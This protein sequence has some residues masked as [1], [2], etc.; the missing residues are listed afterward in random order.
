[1]KKRIPIGYEDFKEIIEKNLYFVDKSMLI[2][3]LADV[4][5][6]TLFTRPRRF[7]KTLN[8]SMIRRY[9]EDERTPAGEKIDNSCLFD[10]LAIMDAGEEYCSMQQQY[11]VIKLSLKSAKQPDFEMA[12]SSMIDDI[13]LEFDRHR[14]ILGTGVLSDAEEKRYRRI[15]DR[16]AE[17]AEYAKALLFLSQYLQKYHRQNVILLID[18]YDVPLENAYFRGF[19]DEMVDFIRSLFESALKTNDCLQFGVVTGCLRIS[20]ESIF[21]G[22]NNLKINSVLANSYGEYFGFLQSEVDEMLAYYGIEDKQ[23]TIRKWYDGYQF[24]NKEIYNPWS[25]LSY[26][27]D[28]RNQDTQFPKPYWVN[29]SSNDII[30]QLVEHA[31]EETKAE[32]ERLISG[33]TIEKPVHEEITYGDIHKSMDNLWNFLLFTGYLKNC[34]E[35]FEN[36]KIYMQMAIPNLEIRTI[37]EDIILEWFNGRVKESDRSR[38]FTAAAAGDVNTMQSELTDMLQ[39]S[40]S[41][42]DYAENYYHGFLTGVLTGMNGYTAI[43]NRESGNGRPDLI[44]RENKFMGK[45][46]ILELKVTDKFTE[47]AGKCEEALAQI[48]ENHYDRPLLDEG[49]QEIIKYGVCFF[50]KGCIVKKA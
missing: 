6:V 47:M 50:K 7:G 26:V 36:N 12:Y 25:I 3:E 5:K 15:L 39:Q 17:K 21:T 45:A 9:F 22:L 32:M 13:V 28:I 2:K 23:E 44:L 37:Y 8:L 34:G 11:P 10:G 43:S 46:I 30:R 29:T 49:C 38:L 19:Y 18:E 27:D 48:E 20:R 14:Y 35:R 42:F 1:M 16:E 4:G 40:I 41:F 31:D 24:G 33:E